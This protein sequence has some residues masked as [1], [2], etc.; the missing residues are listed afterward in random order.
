MKALT[1]LLL[2][3]LSLSAGAAAATPATRPAPAL[4]AALAEAPDGQ[5]RMLKI[6][7]LPGV[8]A[9]C[10]V[11]FKGRGADRSKACGLDDD[12]WNMDADRPVPPGTRLHVYLRRDR[13]E[14]AGLDRV[15]A[16]ASSCALTDEAA[17]VPQFT[18]DEAAATTLLAGLARQSPKRVGNNAIAVLALQEGD[19]AGRALEALSA[20]GEADRVR[21]DA[22]FWLTQTRGAQGFA[23]VQRLLEDP[24]TPR[25]LRRHAVFAL[26]QSAEAGR[27]AALMALS[28][29]DHDTEIRGEALFWLAQVSPDAAE[30]A[31]VAAARG[32]DFRIADKAIFGLSQLPSARAVPAL[33]TLARDR[34]LSRKVRKQALFWLSQTD[35][36]AA[37]PEMDRLLGVER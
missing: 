5:W 25:N 19:Q 12:G 37:M 26:S 31:L 1:A 10:C 15:R 7:L 36:D 20:A 27:D 18:L 35:A 23:A 28:R 30:P 9:P 8:G 17:A 24:Q 2:S 6:D 13:S 22:T 33:S 21:R 32:A 16:F 14:P 11:D 29:D 3:L 34:G 4:P